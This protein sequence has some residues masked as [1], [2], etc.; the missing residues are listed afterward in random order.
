MTDI[1]SPTELAR[2]NSYYKVLEINHLEFDQSYL[3]RVLA[4]QNKLSTILF[5]EEIVIQR[6]SQPS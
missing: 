1:H 6:G 4:S 5:S 3:I 2:L